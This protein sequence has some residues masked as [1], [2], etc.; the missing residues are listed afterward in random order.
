MRLLLDTHTVIWHFSGDSRLPQHIRQ[1]LDNKSNDVYVSVISLWEMSIK[2]RKG[3]LEL[4]RSLADIIHHLHGNGFRF[5]SIHLDHVYCL[6][7]LTLHHND[8]FDRMLIAQSI[9]GGFVLVSCD[10]MFDRYDVRRL[11]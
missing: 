11:W 8:P 10:E 5:L 1:I 4:H 6:D 9:D 3:K 7:S 2:S